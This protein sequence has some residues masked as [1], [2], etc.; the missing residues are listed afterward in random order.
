MP[1]SL[2]LSLAYFYNN[3]IIVHNDIFDLSEFLFYVSKTSTSILSSGYFLIQFFGILF[4]FA[5]G[6][7]Y[8]Q[9]SLSHCGKICNIF[10]VDLSFDKINVHFLCRSIPP[11]SRKAKELSKFLT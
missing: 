1:S 5:N 6:L 3:D 2:V 10:F 7:F 9:G 4:V 8:L 11:E